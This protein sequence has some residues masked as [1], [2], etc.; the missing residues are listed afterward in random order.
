S[1]F[2]FILKNV[3]GWI[4]MLC[5]LPLGLA[6]PGPGGL[7]IFLIGFALV[8]FPGKR[9]LTARVMRG[10]R[11]HLEDS[12][13]TFITAIASL[14]VTGIIIWFLKTNYGFLIQK[15]S[16]RPGSVV[17]L[18]VLAA[19]VTWLVT[20]LSLKVVNLLVRGMP[21][22]RRYIRPWLRKKG[23]HL[24]PPRRRIKL[25][26]DAAKSAG[27]TGKLPG[28]MPIT[29]Y[30]TG[31]EEE[32]LE[33]HERH[34]A[35][36]RTVWAGSKV[37]L[38]RAASLAITIA[39]LI[40]ILKP[41]GDEW[42]TIREKML[43]I[44]VIIRVLVG[45]AIFA[46]FLFCFRAMMWRHI[47]AAFGNPLPVPAAARIWSISELARY[48]PGSIWQ[49]V[50]RV[51]LSKPYGVRGSVCSTSQVLEVFIFLLANV[52]VA[53]SCL[54]YFGFR[55]D[56]DG[57]AR[58]WLIIAMVLVP[59][60]LF[61]LHPRVFH[62]LANKVL[63]RLGKPPIVQQLSGRAFLGL[64]A[65][66]ILGLLVQSFAVW[67]VAGGTLTLPINKW[68]VVA[69]AYC[70]AW[71]AG[72]LAFWSPGGLGVREVV[73][74]TVLMAA[75]LPQFREQMQGDPRRLEATIAFLSI[76]LRVW[77]TI[78]ELILAAITM[79]TD[80]RGAIGR[81]DAPGRVA[82]VHEETAAPMETVGSA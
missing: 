25:V 80:Y 71:C 34:H 2:W 67:I 15:Y 17:G 50:G 4:L 47:L 46:I 81:P 29:Q 7:P 55:R 40:W 36:F 9:R 57:S 59:T 23:I 77:A 30:E 39:I 44:D 62:P 6:L 1:Y 48:L 58:V 43:S 11:M 8:T 63:A 49:V 76:L 73:F 54:V 33:I 66:A 56:T 26:V 31:S 35:R 53:L 45:S 61:I 74:I 72:F 68:W 82:V 12:L 65:W 37:W 69:G 19:A 13:F 22:A 3:I 42:P 70:L 32:I 27:L 79:M 38:R 51:Y 28:Q 75:P 64:I 20:R 10:R 24:L 16:I 78:G 5:A 52:L 21:R 14:A 18:C 41:I 60:L